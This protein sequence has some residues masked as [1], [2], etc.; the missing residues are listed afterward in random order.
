[1]AAKMSEVNE[2][3]GRVLL[4]SALP[5]AV[6]RPRAAQPLRSDELL[7]LVFAHYCS[8]CRVTDIQTMAAEVGVAHG[9]TV[10]R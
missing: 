5:S 9:L 4:Q 2:V 1:M 3:V 8:I 7:F 10:A 6:A